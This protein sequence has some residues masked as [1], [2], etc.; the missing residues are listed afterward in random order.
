MRVVLL[1]AAVVAALA[2]PAAHAAQRDAAAVDAVAFSSDGFTLAVGSSD[3]AVRFWDIPT[4][5]QT[6]ATL[7]GGGDSALPIAF[8]RDGHTL[9]GSIGDGVSAWD[10][11]A[12]TERG[13]AFAH[14]EAAV[15]FDRRTLV[16]ADSTA[17]GAIALW[18]TTTHQRTATLE[19]SKG[20]WLEIALSR[21]GNTVAAAGSRGLY[22]WDVRTHRRIG[23]A[24]DAGGRVAGVA[25]SPDG[26]TIAV[27]DA[28]GVRLWSL[29]TQA[30]STPVLALTKG[31]SIVTFSPDGAQLVTVGR[32]GVFFWNPKNGTQVAPELA[33]AGPGSDITAFA[34]GPDGLSFATGTRDGHTSIWSRVGHVL[35]GGPFDTQPAPAGP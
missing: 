28:R 4:G 12:G 33:N 22:L 23:K 24:V 9:F 29:R 1:A 35:I 10:V 8:S 31:T 11:E 27:S 18:S 14:G 26:R 15:S 30:Y 7:A 34:F 5:R 21:D 25:F 17:G 2:V 20:P 6:D 19:Q 16:V 32:Q 3:G 13:S